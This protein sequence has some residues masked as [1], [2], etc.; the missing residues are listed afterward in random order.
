MT[1]KNGQT[2][3]EKKGIEARNE[4]LI[5]NEWVKGQLEYT[6]ALISSEYKIQNE[7]LVS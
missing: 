4:H 5:R 3:I 6:K 1:L 2:C 7:F